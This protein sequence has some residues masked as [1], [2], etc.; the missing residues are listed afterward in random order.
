MATLLALAILIFGLRLT[1][2]ILPPGVRKFIREAV[3]L[4]LNLVFGTGN[5]G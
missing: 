4:L 2:Q 5:K 1:F 3:N